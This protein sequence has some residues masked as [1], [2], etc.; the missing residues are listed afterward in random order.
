[1]KC[2]FCKSESGS[3]RSVEHIIPE[4]IGN[5]EHV[6]SRGIVCDQCNS[7]FST[8]VEKPF[9]DTSYVRDMCFH[10]QIRNKKGH[11][12]FVASVH[13]QSG[14]PVAMY[15]NMD[16]EGFSI[17][18]LYQGDESKWIKSLLS[19]ERGT[20]VIPIPTLPAVEL[21]S[22][23]VA[24]VALEALALRV[25]NVEGGI[26]EIVDKPELDPLRDYA[27]RGKGQFWP[28]E[29]RRLYP[30]DFVFV[31][32][33]ADPY[34]VLHEWT[35]L[36]TVQHELYF[37][38]GLFG[39]EYAMNMGGRELDGYRRWLAEHSNRSPLYPEGIEGLDPAGPVSGSDAR[40]I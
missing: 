26:K 36:Y 5:V 19:A 17:A 3:S 27:R 24:K 32:A 34:E 40:G 7:Y 10:A 37:V 2:I 15:P 39:N 33:G 6:L 11:P 16:G 29:E 23:F 20:L 1:M 22:R 13:L 35:F 30:P 28:V 18:A 21:L 4:S 25:L 12:P 9:L 38:L 31:K 14:V 8:K